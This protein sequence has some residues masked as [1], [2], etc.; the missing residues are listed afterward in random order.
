LP[1]SAVNSK[2]G[3]VVSL[4]RRRDTG[5]VGVLKPLLTA[6]DESLAAATAVALGQ[7]GNGDARA[8]LLA[9]KPT[10]A[11]SDALLAI[12][13][14]SSGSS[15]VAMYKGLLSEKHSEAVRIAAMRGLARTD[16]KPATVVLVA[17]LKSE[18][19]R[20][21]AIGVRE[22][23]AIEGVS[24]AKRMPGLPPRAQ[25]QMIS[26]LVDSGLPD[27]LPV[28][29]QGF[30]SGNE[31]VRVA[32]LNG[33]AK[34]GSAK[35]IP[36]LASHAASTTGDEQ[37]AA[38]VALGRIRGSDADAAVLSSIAD[39][40]PRTKVEL[41]RAAGERGISNAADVLLRTATDTDRQVRNES[42]RAL[43][44]TAGSA[45]VPTLVSLLVK[46]HD[47]NDRKEYERTVAA[48]IHRAR[49]APIG[50]LASAYRAAS[51]VKVKASL[52]SVMAAVGNGDALPIVREALKASEADVQRAA[53][54]ALSAWPSPEPMKDLLTLAQSSP[55]AAHQV[56]ALRG[57]VRLAQIPSNRT[58][59]E[60]AKLLAAAMTA[61]KRAEE[62]KMVIAAAQRVITPES[63]ELVKAVVN[64][65]AVA[66]EA[67]AAIT[68]LER[69]LTYRRN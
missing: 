35:Q 31:S 38:R 48:A 15:A 12:A 25:V 32:S 16:A 1:K 26:A 37:A 46:T 56:L 66:A 62:K 69:S 2:A 27:V 54:N 17:A 55:N 10:A 42:I 14:R 6:E 3:I 64:D 4:G 50:E 33:I 43:R 49:E 8:A 52:L 53:V 11:V 51:D 45:H 9:A 39:A 29:E 22:L 65:P 30:S 41:I 23:A 58:P 68:A 5:A 28:L 57:Y 21:Q 47:E 63:V 24:V 44:E 20:L 34:L 36:M 59:A 61:S 67:K 40:E 13:E 19:P 60:T 18:S 7:I